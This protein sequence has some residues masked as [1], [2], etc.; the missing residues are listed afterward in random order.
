MNHI[1]TFR[2]KD[3]ENKNLSRYGNLSVSLDGYMTKKNET[4]NDIMVTILNTKT[5]FYSGDKFW[6]DGKGLQSYEHNT[7]AAN[8][9]IVTTHPY[10]INSIDGNNMT[11]TVTWINRLDNQTNPYEFNIQSLT[12]NETQTAFNQINE[13]KYKWFPYNLGCYLA[14]FFLMNVWCYIRMDQRFNP[15]HDWEYWCCCCGLC[16]LGSKDRKKKRQAHE[17][18]LADQNNK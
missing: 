10:L 2:F 8:G 12:V 16:G 6:I 17:K 3:H 14:F 9:T 1:C 18:L 5:I 4:K 13:W 11:V 15:H 7:T